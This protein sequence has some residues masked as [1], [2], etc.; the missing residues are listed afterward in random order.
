MRDHGYPLRAVVG[1]WY[2]MAW[3]KWVAHITVV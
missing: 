3:V 2:G 1:G